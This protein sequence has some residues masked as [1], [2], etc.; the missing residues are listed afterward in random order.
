MTSLPQGMMPDQDSMS[1]SSYP[2]AWN[3]D[4]VTKNMLKNSMILET[5]LKMTLELIWV[6]FFRL[7]C[8]L[9]PKVQ[10]VLQP[11]SAPLV[12]SICSTIFAKRSWRFWAQE[13]EKVWLFRHCTKSQTFSNSCAQNRHDLLA[14]I[15]EH[16]VSK[17]Y[18]LKSNVYNNKACRIWFHRLPRQFLPRDHGGFGHKN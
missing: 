1:V 14:K 10:S 15:I 11:R 17:L 12:P 2:P 4:L 5:V 6:R 8:P 3:P 9:I 16:T 7:R 18:M 13:S